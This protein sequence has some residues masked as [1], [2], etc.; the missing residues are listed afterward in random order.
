MFLLVGLGN[1]GKKYENTR[2]NVG[3]KAVDAF[4]QTHGFDAFREKFKGRYARGALHAEELVVLKPET[5][6]NLSG[7]SVAPAAAFF[8]V[9]PKCI[10]AVHD[11]LDL[12]FG[13]I[14]V[15]VGGGHGGHNGLRS[16]MGQLG[17]PEFVRIRVGIGRPPPGFR[18]EVA[19][20]VL[21][22]WDAME[23]AELPALLERATQMVARV[24]EK[25]PAVAM[26]ELHGKASAKS[27]RPL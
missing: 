17:T 23:S 10:V 9:A 13:D 19:D 15:K 22:A 14:R 21:G 27:P 2:H 25:G 26:N 7:E 1:P 8:H 4:A 11:E 16:M 20:Y 5:F 24:V 3:F 12:P 6:M 18:G